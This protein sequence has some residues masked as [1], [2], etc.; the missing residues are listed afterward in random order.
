MCSFAVSPTLFS[1]FET[2]ANP[3]PCYKCPAHCSAKHA[4][5]TGQEEGPKV[6]EEK[7]LLL[8]D[9]C[10]F[11]LFSSSSCILCHDGAVFIGQSHSPIF[12]S[13]FAL[14]TLFLL[15]NNCYLGRIP[16]L[17]LKVPLP[18]PPFPPPCEHE[19]KRA[20]LCFLRPWEEEEEEEEEVTFLFPIY[21]PG[22]QQQLHFVL[23]CIYAHLIN[24]GMSSSTRYKMFW[25]SL[26][27][28]HGLF[29]RSKRP[30]KIHK[31]CR[32]IKARLFSFK[33]RPSAYSHFPPKSVFFR[34]SKYISSI[35]PPF[36]SS[37]NSPTDWSLSAESIYIPLTAFSHVV[38]MI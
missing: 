34:L 18:P 4:A 38:D 32:A 15:P 21:F 11:F 5:G 28:K 3:V 22:K 26:G 31:L 12:F 1:A 35:Y 30:N 36:P 25:L 37:T 17:S 23:I 16:P 19:K 33:R 9:L 20:F 14:W 7:I 8:L 24:G 13:I 6:V 2:W 10:V 27:G 29:D